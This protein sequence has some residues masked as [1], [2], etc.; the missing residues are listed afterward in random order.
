MRIALLTLAVAAILACSETG[1]DGGAGGTGGAPACVPTAP[2][3]TCEP[4]CPAG[5]SCW[6]FKDYDRYCGGKACTA[7]CCT[8]ADCVAFFSSHANA[9]N[10][11]CG[12]DHL[13]FPVGFVGSFFCAAQ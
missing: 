6:D 10:A 4:D 8:D 7:P 9:A 12:T 13:C 3:R 1:D 5:Q 2:A 11:R